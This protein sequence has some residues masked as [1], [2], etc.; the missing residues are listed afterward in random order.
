[1]PDLK[2]DHEHDHDSYGHDNDNGGGANIAA[3][4]M[5]STALT[6]L[7]ALAATLSNV[8]VT[9]VIGHSGMPMLT[10]KRD[11]KGTWSFGR[12][13]TEVEEGSRWAVNPLTF[14]R[15]YICF[16]E[17][18]KVIGEKFVSVSQPAPDPAEL[19]DTGY[20]W[21]EQW[22]VNLKCVTGA[23]AGTEVTYKPTTVGGVRAVAELIETVRER[24]NGGLH[25]GR[26][27]PI[28][29][30]EKDSYDGGQYGKVWIPVLT[31]VDWM[32]LSGPTPAP[33]PTSPT[34]GSGT[35]EQPRR[36]RVA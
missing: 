2:H 21:N 25:D 20:K 18:N 12:K 35:A 13:R 9:S 23:D 16:G 15:G 14:K 1:M 31:V 5:G 32:P 3:A 8:D 36:R 7:T 28:V 4:A 24:L 19:P 34:I 11:N 22:G 33:A 29:V 6:S 17:G 26:V 10:F 27:A 30:L